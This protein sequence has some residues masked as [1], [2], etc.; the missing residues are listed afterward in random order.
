[1]SMNPVWSYGM[2][3]IISKILYFH[4]IHATAKYRNEIKDGCFL[5]IEY[6]GVDIDATLN[7]NY[8]DDT[9]ELNQNQKVVRMFVRKTITNG[10]KKSDEMVQMK[11]MRMVK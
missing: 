5:H 3:T 6:G 8:D 11:K 1:M 10:E 2:H 9:S 4:S 7:K